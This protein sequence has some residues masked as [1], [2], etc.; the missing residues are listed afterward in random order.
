MTVELVEPALTSV[1][2]ITGPVEEINKFIVRP[3]MPG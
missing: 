1:V 2:L 3:K